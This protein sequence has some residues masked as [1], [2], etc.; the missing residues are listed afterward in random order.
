MADGA[1]VEDG[2]HEKMGRF[3]LVSQPFALFQ[4]VAFDRD[5]IIYRVFYEMAQLFEHIRWTIQ[6]AIAFF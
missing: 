3:G 4:D 6:D 5:E 2:V 1:Q